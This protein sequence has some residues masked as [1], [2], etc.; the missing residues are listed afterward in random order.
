MIRPRWIE[1]EDDPAEQLPEWVVWL[2]A[3]VIGIAIGYLIW[4]A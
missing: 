2:L 4:G 3:I 1:T